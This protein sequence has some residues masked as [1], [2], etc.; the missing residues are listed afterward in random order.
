MRNATQAPAQEFRLLALLGGAL[1]VLSLLAVTVSRAEEAAPGGLAQAT[2][3]GGCFW[4]MEGPFDAV[5]GVVSTV[6]GYTGGH[7]DDPTYRQ[8]TTGTTGHYESVQVTYD[9]QRVSYEELLRVFWH[10]VDP[11]DDGGQFCDRG[12][13]YRT[14]IFVHSDEQRRIAEESKARLEAE[15]AIEAGG[16]SLRKR[17]A[18][19]SKIH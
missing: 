17:A 15:D 5:E 8:V 9:P 19:R 3:A 12:T 10:N 13:S 6:S 14:A 18:F 16:S 4:C 7:V 2:F 1:L 11:T